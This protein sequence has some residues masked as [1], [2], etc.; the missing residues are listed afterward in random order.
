MRTANWS[1]NMYPGLTIGAVNTLLAHG[2]NA[3]KTHFLPNMSAGK[4]SGT[5]CLT[6]AQCG[7]DLGQV[8]TKAVAN[9][10]GSYGITGSKIFIS[11]GEHDLTDNIIH[12]VLA[13]LPNA[14]KGTR[15]ISLFIVPKINTSES[16]ELLAPNQVFSDDF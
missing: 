12:I 13:R 9:E 8:Q 4:W 5:M 15:G 3:Q 7:T 10:D 11:A 1:F 16:G 6:E 14:P 2:S